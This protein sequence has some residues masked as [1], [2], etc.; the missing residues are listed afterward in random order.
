MGRFSES[1]L[2]RLAGLCNTQKT[3]KCLGVMRVP[4]PAPPPGGLH[5]ARTTRRNLQWMASK[6]NLSASTT[7]LSILSSQQRVNLGD[8]S[9]GSFLKETR[10]AISASCMLPARHLYRL[11]LDVPWCCSYSHETWTWLG[12]VLEYWKSLQTWSRNN[13]WA[14]THMKCILHL[15]FSFGLLWYA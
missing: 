7:T 15:C 13:L 3:N 14:S 2:Q 4:P 5:L 8:Y 10:I 1:L 12:K 11:Y 6:R 9:G